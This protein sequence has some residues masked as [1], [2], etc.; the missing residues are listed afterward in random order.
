M[1]WKC[2]FASLYSGHYASGMRIAG[3]ESAGRRIR[4][5][6][7]GIRPT[8]ERTR[9]ALF[10]I[11]SGR[12]PGSRFLDLFAGS[13]AIGFEAWSRGASQV[14]W[15]EVDRRAVRLLRDNAASLGIS[16]PSVYAADVVSQLRKGFA[17][18]QFDIIFADPP[19]AWHGGRMPRDAIGKK[20]QSS[21]T[22]RLLADLTHD[23]KRLSEGGLLIIEQGAD[24]SQDIPPGW[25]LIDQRKYGKTRL[26]FFCEEDPLS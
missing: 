20:G 15:V 2:W 22:C 14:C 16:G 6:E 26:L 12:V 24:D 21:G 9:E 19:Y 5:L 8:T 23:N 17:V 1:L 13:G 25:R 18:G 10:S 7:K 3:G 11:I 4:V